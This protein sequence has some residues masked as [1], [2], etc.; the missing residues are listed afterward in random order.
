MF[1]LESFLRKKITYETSSEWVG[2]SNILNKQLHYIFI[3]ISK[4]EACQEKKKK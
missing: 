4:D 2:V 1:F 3:L